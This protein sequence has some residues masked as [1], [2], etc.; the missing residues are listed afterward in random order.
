MKSFGWQSHNS[1]MVSIVLVVIPRFARKL[2]IV[3]LLIFFSERK[4]II[5]ESLQSQDRPARGTEKIA[6][7]GRDIRCAECSPA[8][9]P[10]NIGDKSYRP[11]D[12]N[13]RSRKD[14]RT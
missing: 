3:P 10:Q 13:S 6:Q 2:I 5:L 8:Q 9:I 12:A 1:Q 14:F 7:T 4:R 11:R